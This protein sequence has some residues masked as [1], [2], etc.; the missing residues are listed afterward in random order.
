MK[1]D[2]Q[3]FMSPRNY[4]IWKLTVSSQNIRHLFHTWFPPKT[5]S[6]YLSMFQKHGLFKVKIDLMSKDVFR[7]RVMKG[8]V[9]VAQANTLLSCVNYVKS[10]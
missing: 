1:D 10:L 2:D 8:T 4:E 6:M 9:E 5:D 3:I 7:F